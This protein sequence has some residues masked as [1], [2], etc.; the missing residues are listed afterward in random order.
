MATSSKG[1]S[2]RGSKFKYFVWPHLETAVNIGQDHTAGTSRRVRGRNHKFK[3]RLT[4]ATR[5][6][7]R[8]ARQRGTLGRRATKVFCAGA[9]PALQYGADVHGMLD[10][11]LLNIRRF[12]ATT[13]KPSCGGRSPCMIIRVEG[14]PAWYG[15]VAQL[16]HQHRG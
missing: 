3:T 6:T 7:R 4:A 11:E 12:A 15:S 8:L 5:R 10:C 9:L 2:P 1:F 13:M 14:D 16:L